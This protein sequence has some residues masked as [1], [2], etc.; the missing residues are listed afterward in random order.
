MV[1]ADGMR[2]KAMRRGEKIQ[3]HRQP[4]KFS[5][6]Q[7]PQSAPAGFPTLRSTGREWQMIFYQ[8]IQKIEEIKDLSL[9]PILPLRHSHFTFCGTEIQEGRFGVHHKCKGT[10]RAF[11]II[12]NI[13]HQNFLFCI[14]EQ[15]YAKSR[16]DRYQKPYRTR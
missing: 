6:G 4:N 13:S 3:R 14:G 12:Y 15:R 10:S 5:K 1:F 7:L 8:K 16:K 2:C 11:I 9:V